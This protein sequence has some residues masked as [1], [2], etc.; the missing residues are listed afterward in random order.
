MS[1]IFIS[2]GEVSGDAYGALL[3][4]SLRE[5]LPDA[6]IYGI[7]GDR[8]AAAGV[9]LLYHLRDVEAMGLVEVVAKIPRILSQIRKTARF[10]RDKH[11]TLFLPIDFPDFNFRVIKKI[12]KHCNTFYYSPPQLWAWR[13]KRALFLK[14][15]VRGIGVIFPFEIDFYRRYG[16]DVLFTGH[17]MAEQFHDTPITTDQRLQATADIRSGKRPPRIGLL[18]GSRMSEVSAILPI[19]LATVDH[20]RRTY[21]T[22]SCSLALAPTIDAKDLA[23]IPGFSPESITLV[24]DVKD[25][26]RTVDLVLGASGTAS[27]Q[28]SLYPVPMI[29]VY[30]VNPLSYF[31]AKHLVK[32]PYIGIT[33]IILAKPVIPEFIQKQATPAAIG[34]AARSLLSDS[35]RVA[36][37]LSAFDR[38]QDLLYRPF[39]IDKM[40]DHIVLMLHGDV[41]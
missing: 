32:V 16:V 20:L 13:S 27:L 34:S 25:L 18:P 36:D 12:H 31:I 11:I 33:N 41:T 2:A 29:I 40:C 14:R 4:R 21:P 6:P 35:T 5:R 26:F 8:M 15:Y 9:D 10:I 17:P 39:A 24:K 23:A 1:G 19:L 22:L 38:L 3:A 7:G 28:A 30:K 37:Q